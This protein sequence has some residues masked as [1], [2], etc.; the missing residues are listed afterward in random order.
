MW[1]YASLDDR[2]ARRGKLADDPRW[3]AFIPRLS[4]LI[5][6]SENRILLPTDFS[7]LR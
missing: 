2:S 4:A 7:P 5:E 1:G 6:S 3:Q